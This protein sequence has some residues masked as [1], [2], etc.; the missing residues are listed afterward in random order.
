MEEVVCA[1]RSGFP[2]GPGAWPEFWTLLFWSLA[3]PLAVRGARCERVG[4]R[5]GASG[6]L[7][8][9]LLPRVLCCLASCSRPCVLY[10]LERTCLARCVC[11][12]APG[13]DSVRGRCARVS[14]L[15]VAHGT[16]VEIQKGFEHVH[17]INRCVLRAARTSLELA[18]VS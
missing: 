10:S 4:S 14:A 8:R 18:G 12:G 5:F 1:E 9:P 7:S 16:R 6:S 13:A 3:T 2:F 17:H 15:S 11:C